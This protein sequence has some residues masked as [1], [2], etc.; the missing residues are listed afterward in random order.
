VGSKSLLTEDV[1]RSFFI[2]EM[3]QGGSDVWET[4]QEGNPAVGID[5]IGAR[6]GGTGLWWSCFANIRANRQT[7]ANRYIDA[8]P[9]RHA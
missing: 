8:E 7:Y 6:I 5:C 2:R 1:W 4:R 9:H 3:D